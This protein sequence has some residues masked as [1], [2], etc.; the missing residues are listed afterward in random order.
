M[1]KSKTHD[2][3]AAKLAIRAK[4][5]VNNLE[6]GGGRS[7]RTMKAKRGGGGC[8]GFLCSGNKPANVSELSAV[9]PV[10]GS[11][12]GVVTNPLTA[13]TRNAGVTIASTPEERIKRLQADIERYKGL[14]RESIRSENVRGQEQ[15]SSLI[16]MARKL[17]K[18]LQT[19]H[20]LTG[21]R[22]STHRRSC[23]RN[24]R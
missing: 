17:I 20:G 7:R 11:N 10:V 5:E 9:G 3:I 6:K 22:R 1:N 24:R 14:L 4:K 8:F 12:S 23:R 13:T 19:E 21:G 15:Y 18:K 16:V 2:F